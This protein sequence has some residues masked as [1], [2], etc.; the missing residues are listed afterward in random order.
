MNYPQFIKPF[1]IEA[2][3]Q[4]IIQAFKTK[5]SKLDYIPVIGDDYM[6]LID[7]FLYE[8]SKLIEFINYQISNNYLNY[9][10]GEYLDE[11]VSLLDIKRIKA[12]KPIATISI[13][14]N[15]PTTLPKGT[16]LTDTAGH[17]AYLL[18]EVNITDTSTI[19]T[20]KIE[21]DEFSNE[22]YQTTQ[23]E[24]PNIYI[25]EITITEPFSGF[26]R[27]ESD[28]EL[29]N[30]FLLALHSFSTAG[31]QKAYLFYI[32][33]DEAIKKARVYKSNDGEVTITYLSELSPQIAQEKIKAKLQGRVPLTDKIV[34]K[35]AIKINVDLVVKVDL[36]NVL[37]LPNII[38]TG[39]KLTHELFNDL[40]IG[41]SLHKSK[42]IDTI[43]NNNKNI[44]SVEVTSDVPNA[45]ADDILILNSIAISKVDN[46]WFKSL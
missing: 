22:N 41:Q 2:K 34:L 23:L 20:A 1:D 11:L 24:I 28:D 35:E 46:A 25:S 10:T 31:S 29:K 4:E 32:L 3:R 44:L 6:T 15:S 7:I 14:A 17:F 9:S 42:I 26:S 40:Q 33:S 18:S 27:A 13:K 19:A 38:Q 5:S 21:L 36:K 39:T 30:R 43:F 16:K 37:E 8:M 45:G 12:T